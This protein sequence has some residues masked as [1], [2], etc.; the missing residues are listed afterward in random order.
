MLF[1]TTALLATLLATQSADTTIAV[2]KGTRL[3]VNNHEGQ[4]TVT[5]WGRD[6]VQIRST[7]NDGDAGVRVERTGS[8][9][10]VS[11]RMRHGPS[12]MALTISAPAWMALD[13]QG[14]EVGITV[15]G[16]AGPIKARSVDGDVTLSGGAG[17][18]S[19]SS[20]DGSVSATGV[21]GSLDIQAVDGEVRV[22]N[23]VGP[24]NIQGIDGDILLEDIT[25][26]SVR[27]NTVDGSISYSGTFAPSG[28]YSLKTHDGGI[29]IRPQGA[30]NA[31]VSVAT[32]DGEFESAYPITITGNQAGKRFTF[33]LGTGSARVELD[34]FDGLI[35]ID[36]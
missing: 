18:V 8:E 27:V 14:V 10:L 30:F 21:R 22:R 35:R 25:S 7:T 23:L 29:T 16:M 28:S 13:L 6:E 26:P 11:Q 3:S 5:G 32:W 12:E 9:L 36:K 1:T 2:A 17:N 31:T 4:I 34:S 15:S 19:L 24:L 33:T 20:T